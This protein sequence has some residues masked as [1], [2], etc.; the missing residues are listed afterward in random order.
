MEI[1]CYHF[2]LADQILS[3]DVECKHKENIAYCR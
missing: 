3:M 1:M 2:P